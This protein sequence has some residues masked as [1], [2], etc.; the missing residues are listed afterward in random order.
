MDIEFT[1][2]IYVF[3]YY[4]K[5][6]FRLQCNPMFCW[7]NP[8]TTLKICVISKH[9]LWFST[10]STFSSSYFSFKKTFCFIFFSFPLF[11]I[12]LPPFVPSQIASLWFKTIRIQNS[13]QQ[14]SLINPYPKCLVHI[15]S[16]TQLTPLTLL[17]KWFPIDQP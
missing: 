17:S 12:T 3:L 16:H 9:S 8:K 13:N 7:K 11:S 14:S 5:H 1:V 6:E 10:V 4:W 2:E 15:K